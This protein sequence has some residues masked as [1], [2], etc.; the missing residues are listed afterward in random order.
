M[1]L[2]REIWMLRLLP[3]KAPKETRNKSLGTGGWGS[4]SCGGRKLMTLSLVVMRK[5][6][7]VPNEPSDLAKEM[8]KPSVEGTD[9]FLLTDY[10]RRNLIEGKIIKQKN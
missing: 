4:M 3:V 2:V 8:S 7:H 10:V 6:E 5:A 1:E 9:G